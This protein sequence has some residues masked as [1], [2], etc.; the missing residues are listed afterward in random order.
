MTGAQHPGH[1]GDTGPG[2]PSQPVPGAQGASALGAPAPA[3]PMRRIAPLTALPPPPRIGPDEPALPDEI[4]LESRR[5]LTR[6]LLRQVWKPALVIAALW[7]LLVI[8][9]VQSTSPTMWALSPLYLGSDIS[10]GT[11]LRTLGLSP[12]GVTAALLLVPVLG[13]AASIALVPVASARIARLNPRHELTDLAFLRRIARTWARILLAPVAATIGVLGLAVLCQAPLAWS[14]LSYGVLAGFAGG[15]GLTWC[16]TIAARALLDVTAV[17]GERDA[18]DALAQDRRHLPPSAPLDVPRV[19]WRSLL[20]ALRALAVTAGAVVLPLAWL[21]FGFGDAVVVFGRVSD[22]SLGSRIDTGLSLATWFVGGV[23]LALAVA[24]MA[25]VP[26]IA[27]RTADGLRSQVTDL[28]TYPAW[29]DRALVNPWERRVCMVIAAADTGIALAALLL[30]VL[31]LAAVGGLDAMAWIWIVLDLVLV[32]PVLFGILLWRMRARLRDVVYGPASAHMRRRCPAARIAP[33]AGTR[34]EL[35]ADP[36]VRQRLRAAAGDAYGLDPVWSGSG[37]VGSG[38]GPVG[39]GPD[40]VGSGH[41]PGGSAAGVAGR[42]D[43]A[44]D[45]PDGELPDFGATG[46]SLT[47]I[48]RRVRRDDGSIPEDLTDLGRP[49]RR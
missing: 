45:L 21:V 32:I 14:D 37:P 9:Y 41:G 27:M 22:P 19:L 17:L 33:E 12:W 39:S 29:N 4:L 35:A 13:T 6:R 26:W 2:A 34:S 49:R 40:L 16:A 20:E 10:L 43:P 15:I 1:P 11:L 3:V 47:P 5:D 28:R 30:L 42:P 23:L 7:L 24:A 8:G 36:V 48:P 38:P 46:S 31:S 25:L 44:R 18:G